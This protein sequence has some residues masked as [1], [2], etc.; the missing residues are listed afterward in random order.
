MR[1]STKGRIRVIYGLFGSLFSGFAIYSQYPKLSRVAGFDRNN[2]VRVEENEEKG[3]NNEVRVEENVEKGQRE[4]DSQEEQAEQSE[5]KGLDRQEGRDAQDEQGEQDEEIDMTGSDLSDLISM[6]K[7]RKEIEEM[8]GDDDQDD[9]VDEKH[10]ASH[11][12]FSSNSAWVT[13]SE[14]TSSIE[15]VTVTSHSA[16]FVVETNEAHT[17]YSTEN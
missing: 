11:E 3:Q 10:R 13:R 17:V 5:Q 6:E 14:S 12:E 1:D 7:E 2:E 8:K 9:T 4:R 15:K 16:S